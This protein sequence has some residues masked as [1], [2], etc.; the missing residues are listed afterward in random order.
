ML[1]TFNILQFYF[2]LCL[3]K[4]GKTYYS[5]I[6]GKIQTFTERQYTMVKAKQQLP[7]IKSLG[8]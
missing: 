3:N 8:N 7:L 2:E 1:Y 4:A 6:T 5:S